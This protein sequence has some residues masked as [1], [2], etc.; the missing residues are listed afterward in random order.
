[1]TDTTVPL[2]TPSE[3]VREVLAT[4]AIA[5]DRMDWDLLARCYVTSASIDLG[6]FFTGSI[7]E[8]ITANSSP[9]GLPSLNSTFHSLGTSAVRVDGTT[10]SAETYATCYHHGPPDHAWC[11]G[12]V[13]VWMRFLDRLT[14]VDGHWRISHRVGAFEWGRNMVTGEEMNLDPTTLSR[15]DRSDRRYELF[16]A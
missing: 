9:S 2:T 16:G 8:Y 4:V 1:M 5:T 12:F 11:Q 10:A 6:G 14:V 13:V 7:E 15:R 3:A